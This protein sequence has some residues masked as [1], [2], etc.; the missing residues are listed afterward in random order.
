MILLSLVPER[1]GRHGRLSQ[2]LVR[3]RVALAAVGIG[4]FV[5]LIVPVLAEL[6]S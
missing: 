5:G 3:G 2:R 4:I 6:S 1:V